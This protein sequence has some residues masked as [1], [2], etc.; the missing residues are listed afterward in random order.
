MKGSTL[1]G[2]LQRPI[3]GGTL[4]SGPKSGG[5][6]IRKFAQTLGIGRKNGAAG[7]MFGEEA[8]LGF[9]TKHNAG[10]SNVRQNP[11]SKRD[12]RQDLAP[13]FG[14]LP[15]DP[16]IDLQW[17]RSRTDAPR[18]AQTTRT[19][20]QQERE[21]RWATAGVAG[22]AQVARAAQAP[23]RP[24]RLCRRHWQKPDTPLEWRLDANRGWALSPMKS[25]GFLDAVRFH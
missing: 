7:A 3:V 1:L 22:K 21:R 15:S 19:V 18:G 9:T 24:I 13:G 16:P 23:G 12:V 17:R 6:I 4:G 5:W 2:A 10:G 14:P 20:P 11:R 25:Q 8:G